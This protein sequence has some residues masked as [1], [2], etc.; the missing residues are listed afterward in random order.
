LWIDPEIES[1]THGATLIV[2]FCNAT[3]YDLEYTS[4]NGTV[5]RFLTKLSNSSTT[6]IVQGS[7][8]YTKIG[9]PTLLQAASIAG[10]GDTAQYVADEFALSYSQAA[11]GVA[12][13]AFDPKPA[14]ESQ[15]R[16]NLLVAS[17]PKAPLACLVLANLLLAV[18]GIILTVLALLASRGD[19]AEIQSRL[20]IPALVA[21][22]FE[23]DW[24]SQPVEQ[25]EDMFKER[26]GVVGTRIGFINSAQ[27]GWIFGSWRPVE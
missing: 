12:S 20:S 17:V 21:A 16:E 2:M 5:T 15:L 22:Q 23:G 8:Q 3:V 4:V 19:T 9:E 13:P 25:V 10:L 26:H 27:G 6:N 24:A 11:L 7:Q 18:L 1:S 14:I